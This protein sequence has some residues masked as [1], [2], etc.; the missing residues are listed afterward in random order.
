META[1]SSNV[2]S[3]N[4]TSEQWRPVE[5]WPHE[6]STLGR[7]R[8]RRSGRVLKPTTTRKGYQCVRLVDTRKRGWKTNVHTLVLN[9]FVGR[10]MPKQQCRHLDGNPA[11]NQLTNLCWG[12]AA[13][14]SDD[15]WRM[16]RNANIGRAYRIP[17]EVV[18]AVKA[19][20]LGATRA[21][22]AFGVSRS[23]VYEIRKGKCRG[24]PN[25]RSRAK[26]K[27]NKRDE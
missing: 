1:G 16:G 5:N 7:V 22:A 8:N 26:R 24:G 17:P 3:I 10:R 2:V 12:T 21:A 9:A 27:I 19:S 11:N 4:E 18:E 14:N 15:R 20:S 23:W 13:E 6:V 25:Q